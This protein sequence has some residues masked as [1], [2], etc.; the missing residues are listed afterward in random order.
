L[1]GHLE[2]VQ[3][4]ALV[5]IVSSVAGVWAAFDQ[6]STTRVVIEDLFESRDRPIVHVR[7]RH[8]D[9]PQ[10]R[11]LEATLIERVACHLVHT[12]VAGWVAPVPVEV[13]EAVIHEELLIENLSGVVGRLRKKETAVAVK[14]LESVFDAR[15]V[16]ASKEQR[17]APLLRLVERSQVTLLPS[18]DGRLEARHLSLECGDGFGDAVEVDRVG[19]VGKRCGKH[20]GIPLVVPHAPKKLIFH[21]G[22]T[23]LDWIFAKNRHEGLAFQHDHGFVR[24]G[25]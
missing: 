15:G 22:H 9:I 23:K 18:I 2:A 10:A 12:L 21:V 3:E 24:P 1:L 4:R 11:W 19:L 13:V 14:A 20:L 8:G 7:R 6:A 5:G 17:H 25:Q 16:G